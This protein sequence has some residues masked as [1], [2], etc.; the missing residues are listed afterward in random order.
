[1][2][3]GDPFEFNNLSVCHLVHKSSRLVGPWQALGAVHGRLNT[4]N[5]SVSG[6]TLNHGTFGFCSGA[7]KK[8]FI[9]ADYENASN[10]SGRV[11]RNRDGTIND[12]YSFR[13]QPGAALWALQRLAEA[14]QPLHC[15]SLREFQDVVEKDFWR[16]FECC[17]YEKDMARKL[18]FHS[19]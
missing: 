13:N 4:D 6:E 11:I 9:G 3:R 1:M 18:G 8:D 12:R 10:N 2:V 16:E 5:F 19:S 7:F 15:E 14:L 17:Y